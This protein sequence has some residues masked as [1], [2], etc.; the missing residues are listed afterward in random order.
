MRTYSVR[1]YS[2]SPLAAGREV[3]FTCARH[4][5]AMWLRVQ[6]LCDR[7]EVAMWLRAEC[8]ADPT[9]AMR[10]LFYVAEVMN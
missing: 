4:V 5:I 3:G 8:H 1:A 7:C 2:A 10:I 6:Q 9:P